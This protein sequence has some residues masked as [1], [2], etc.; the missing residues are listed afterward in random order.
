MSVNNLRYKIYR[1]SDGENLLPCFDNLKQ[2]IKRANY[3]AT[4]WRRS[5]ECN[6]TIPDPVGHGWSEVLNGIDIL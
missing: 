4:V 5:L 6:S 3:Q 2:Y 1:A